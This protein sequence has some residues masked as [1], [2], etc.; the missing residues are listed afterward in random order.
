MSNKNKLVSI[1]LVVY[2]G[3][4]LISQ[5]ISSLLAQDYTNFELVISDNASTDKTGEICRSYADKDK[6]IRYVRQKENI[7]MAGNFPFVLG[8]AKGEYFMWAAHDDWW[9]PTFISDLKTALDNNP[10]YGVAMSSIER[11]Y[12]DGTLLEKIFFTDGNDLTRLG[13]Y[14]VLMKLFT[15]KFPIFFMYGLFRTNFLKKILERPLLQ[16]MGNDKII[17]AEASLV[18]RLYSIP[19][20]LQKKTEKIREN[21]TKEIYENEFK[22]VSWSQ[23]KWASVYI[24]SMFKRLITSPLI[25]W[26]R[27]ILVPFFWLI[28]LWGNRYALLKEY[29]P[30][31]WRLAKKIKGKYLSNNKNLKPIV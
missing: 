15:Q 12:E 5:A 21:I 23:R 25:P 31:F 17:I 2:N 9:A 20:I 3:E 26:H 30:E 11:V 10:D 13:H 28:L 1:G 22:E 27:K 18:T 4:K 29:F 24:K 8:E 19:K 16:T 14:R 6:R 7:G